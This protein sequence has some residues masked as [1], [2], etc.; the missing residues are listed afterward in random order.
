VCVCVCVFSPCTHSPDSKA[1]A[2]EFSN[3]R[4]DLAAPVSAGPLQVV[5]LAEDLRLALELQLNQDERDG[6]RAQVPSG[7]ARVLIDWLQSGTV[8]TVCRASDELPF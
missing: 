4:C 7:T 5:H 1:A 6:L 3:S 8:S 2:V